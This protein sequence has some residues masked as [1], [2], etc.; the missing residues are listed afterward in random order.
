MNVGTSTNIISQLKGRDFLTL[1]DFS[2]EEIDYLIDLASYLKEQCEKGIV[3]EP[4]KGKTLGMI[5][6]KPSTRTRVSFEA[7][8]YQLGGMG[9]F[10]STKDI[11][12]ERGESIADTAKVLSGYLDG[13]MIRTFSQERVEELAEHATIPVING[14]TDLYHP[15]QLLADLQTIKEVKGKLAGLKLA[16]IGDGNNMANSL[17][18]AAAK[19]GIDISIAAPKGY[20]PNQDAIEKANAFAC[21][22][23]ILITEDP[24]K[25]VKEADI[26]YTDVWASMGQEKEQAIRQKVFANFQVNQ[27]LVNYA[28]EDFIFMHCLPAHREEE[29]TAEIMDGKHS[30]VFQE[31]ENRLHAQKALMTALM[32]EL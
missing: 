29:V 18:I 26:I 10:L 27:E 3:Y 20:L 21:D 6:E 15:C 23:D 25:A 12:M 16:Y 31:S 22:S 1:V 28:K 2:T 13:I 5:F 9:I 4:L 11:Q 30:V 14:L 17:M 19:M 7:G 8:M 32:G 24:I